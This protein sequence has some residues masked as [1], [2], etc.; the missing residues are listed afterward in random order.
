MRARP[1]GCG[2]C[3][4]GLGHETESK[5]FD[6]KCTARKMAMTKAH[7]GRVLKI[8]KPEEIPNEA[9]NYPYC[10]NI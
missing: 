9:K 5:Y 1:E 7:L 4:K 6:K 2:T 3:L 8:H 10:Y